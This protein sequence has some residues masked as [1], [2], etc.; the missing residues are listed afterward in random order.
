MLVGEL[1]DGRCGGS[2]GT[3]AVGAHLDQLRLPVLVEIGG[4]ERLRVPRPELE[5]VPDLDRRLDPDR[6]PCDRVALE[7][8]ADVR[9]LKR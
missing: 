1:L 9:A 6:A 2:G 7:H 3:E 8:G 4:A 5:D